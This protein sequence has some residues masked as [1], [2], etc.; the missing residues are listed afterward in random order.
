MEESQIQR[1]K[2]DQLHK[3]VAI[4]HDGMFVYANPAFLKRLG[5]H[6]FIELE[7]TPI[8]DLV[9][10]KFRSQLKD[11]LSKSVSEGVPPK[12]QP[13]T[14]ITLIK[15]DGTH[16]PTIL[17]SVRLQFEGEN[18]IQLSIRNQEDV[19]LKNTFLGLPWKF[20]LSALFLLLFLIMPNLLLL[21]LNFNNAPKVYLPADAPAVL[22][23]DKL[24]ETFP[25][26]Q[27]IVMLFE[28]VALFSE[29]FLEAFDRLANKLKS[30]PMI[31]DVLTITTQDHISGTEEGF[32]VDPLIDVDTLEE[33]R[34]WQRMQRALSDRFA[35]RT[36]IAKDGSALAMVVIPVTINESIRR[37]ELEKEIMQEIDKA[38]LTGYL[39]ASAG[40]VIVDVAQLRSMLRDNMVFI[41]ATVIIGLL[42]IWW[43]FRRLLAVL[44]GGIA[45]GVVV[46]TTVAFYVVF[47][48]PF[49]LISS[50]IPPLLSA[51]TVAALVHLFN[52]IHYAANRG[53]SGIKRVQRAL[54]EV[55][56]PSLYAVLTTAVG[57]A[58]LGLSPIPPISIFGLISAGGVVMIYFI[59]IVLVPNIFAHYDHSSW[60]MMRGDWSGWTDLLPGFFT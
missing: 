21:K 25:N 39:T 23:D 6:E 2:L 58:S 43:L 10:A 8:L 57:L 49:N 34:P 44:V 54:E 11:H 7:G 18:A 52:A 55:K 15:R 53:Y 12:D 59:V 42:L 41:P 36:L 20:Y 5:Y 17:T 27:V 37:M 19:S 38:R 32:S 28:G 46:S 35:K 9:I 16:L 24:R 3:P 45:I 60:P 56:K 31:D 22:V 51:L 13:K 33:S 50:I 1:D 48:Q 26:D 4:V 47:N 40:Q 14:K 29:G 30:N